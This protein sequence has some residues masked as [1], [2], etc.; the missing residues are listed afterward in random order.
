MRSAARKWGKASSNFP[1]DPSAV[2]KLFS[3]SEESGLI[4]KASVR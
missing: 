1:F 3:V 4:R 2:P